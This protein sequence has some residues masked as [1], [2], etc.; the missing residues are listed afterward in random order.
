MLNSNYQNQ[1]Y[2]TLTNST[3]TT[4]TT[5]PTTS[6]DLKIRGETFG[7][8]IA[9]IGAAII[10]AMNVVLLYLARKRKKAAIERKA[11]EEATAEPQ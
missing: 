10:L 9:S 4:T 2:V 8:I 6:D 11:L 7:I 5:S 1:N 3:N